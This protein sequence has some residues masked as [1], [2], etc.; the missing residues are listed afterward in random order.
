M[1]RM[2][3]DPVWWIWA[4]GKPAFAKADDIVVL[5]SRNRFSQSGI[6]GTNCTVV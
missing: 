1:P 6:H 3:V 4:G 2:E 5:S